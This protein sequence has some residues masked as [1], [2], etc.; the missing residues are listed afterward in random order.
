MRRSS[1]SC[2]TWLA[3]LGRPS[4]D[5]NAGRPRTLPVMGHLV[6]R[7]ETAATP[8]ESQAIAVASEIDK[9]MLVLPKKGASCDTTRPPYDACPTT[10]SKPP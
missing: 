3:V 1:V 2:D 4:W 10:P 7:R 5:A 9:R 6:V 8:Y